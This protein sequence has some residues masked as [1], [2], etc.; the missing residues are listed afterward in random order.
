VLRD[1]CGTIVPV[2][3]ASDKT[4]M[5]KLSGNQ[6]AYPVYLTIGNISKDVRRKASQHA[7]L[8]LGY[9]PAD[10]F[11]DVPNKERRRLLKKQL[12]HC[13][14]RAVME[15]LEEAGRSGLDMLCA[16]GRTRRV[17][18]LLAAFVGDWPEQSDMAC[19]SQGGCPICIKQ[20]EGRGDER[21]APMR[22]RVSTLRAIDTYLQTG[23]HA[24]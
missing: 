23:R 4:Q 2:I 17:Y 9:L 8:I 14:M 13:T 5:T 19:T 15:P 24:R 21:R 18:P 22:T 10:G 12:L 6:E 16:D 7:T 3:I 1:E 20:N 11:K